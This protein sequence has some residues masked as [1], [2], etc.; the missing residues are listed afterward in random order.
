MLVYYVAEVMSRDDQSAMGTSSQEARLTATL[1]NAIVIRIRRA[2]QSGDASKD[3]R[4]P[5]RQACPE[6]AS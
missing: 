5:G 3:E 6:Q 4:A 1:F 2:R